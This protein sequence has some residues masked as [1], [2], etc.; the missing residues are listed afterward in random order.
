MKACPYCEAEL[1]D[2]VIRCTRC[3]RSLLGD[4]GGA[5]SGAVP[6]L[7]GRAAVAATPPAPTTLPR[8]PER[9]TPTIRAGARPG[10]P[11]PEVVTR[12]ALPTDRRRSGR[13]DLVLL[14]A[15]VAAA[16]AGFLAWRAIA[17]PWVKLVVTDTSDRLDPV[18]VGEITLKARAAVLGTIGQGLSAALVAF[19]LLWLVYGFDRGSTMPWFTNPVAAIGVGLA[20]LLATVV[21]AVVWFVW[22]DA[23]VARSRALR[24]GAEELRE[25]LDRQPAPLVEIHRLSGQMRFGGLMVLALLAA[26]AAWWAYRKRA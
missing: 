14:L 13:P 7:A 11:I 25:L 4:G 26:C 2:S 16:A 19:G 10:S 1:R 6:G 21:S 22:E 12:R 8:R 15:A 17:D 9:W 3:G 5:P 23:A 20:G 18:L 24:M